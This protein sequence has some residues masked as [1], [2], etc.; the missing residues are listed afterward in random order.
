MANGQYCIVDLTSDPNAALDGLTGLTLEQ[1]SEWIAANQVDLDSPI[2]VEEKEF[3][4]KYQ[5]CP[6][7]WV[8]E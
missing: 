5:I 8:V 6:D 4:A 7:N 2:T 3:S 1:A